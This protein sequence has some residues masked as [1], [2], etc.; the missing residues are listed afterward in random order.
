MSGWEEREKS[1]E[2]VKKR[3]Q[4]AEIIDFSLLSAL[5]TS[6]E[7]LFSLS[8]RS[9]QGFPRLSTCLLEQDLS[10]NNSELYWNS[11]RK[12]LRVEFH[13]SLSPRKIAQIGW[14]CVGMYFYD[15]S[16][17]LTL[18]EVNHHIK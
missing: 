10:P 4:E 6:F 12:K 8:L 13:Y 16:L 14:I 15:P 3:V 9:L 17:G 1:A 11:L 7:T 5:P 18:P 2:S